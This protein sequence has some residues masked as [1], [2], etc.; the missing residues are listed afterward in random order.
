MQH[1]RSNSRQSECVLHGT[2]HVLTQATTE[3]VEV[4]RI[5]ELQNGRLCIYTELH[6]VA[7]LACAVMSRLGYQYRLAVCCIGDTE[8]YRA[9]EDLS[10][11][12]LLAAKRLAVA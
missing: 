5:V 7:Q 4:F 2:T 10:L 6:E 1:H 11:E 12:V 3:S 8:H 9:R